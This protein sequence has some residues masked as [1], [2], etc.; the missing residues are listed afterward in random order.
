MVR[1]EKAADQAS[2]G[3]ALH[4]VRVQFVPGAVRGSSPVHPAPDSGFVLTPMPW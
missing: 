3:I 1:L 4:C 2:A